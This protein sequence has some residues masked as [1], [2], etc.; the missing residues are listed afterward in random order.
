MVEGAFAAF[1]AGSPNAHHLANQSNE[2]A[3]FLVV[4]SNR[5]GEDACNYPDDELDRI[6]R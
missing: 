4:G 3:T 2:S 5:P 1:Q 6:Q